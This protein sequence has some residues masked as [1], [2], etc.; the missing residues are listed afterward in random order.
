MIIRNSKTNK[1]STEIK[2]PDCF[3]KWVYKGGSKHFATCSYC[4]TLVNINE[5][6]VIERAVTRPITQT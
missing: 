6:K 5:N 1:F 4:R 2:C 3:H